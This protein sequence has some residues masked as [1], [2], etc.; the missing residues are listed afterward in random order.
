M[1]VAEFKRDLNNNY[2]ILE[3]E[4]GVL[5]SDYQI[6][7]ITV[8]S[9]GGILKC[10]TRILDG[11]VKLYFEITSKQPMTR[12]FEKKAIGME[13]LGRIIMGIK[14][15]IENAGEYLLDV[16]NLIFDPEYIYMN[17][18][19]GEMYFCYLP[20]SENEA[21]SSF[22][23]LA[24]YL[25]GRLDHSDK[26]GVV[27][28]YELYKCTME[29]NYSM[30][31]I[32]N[33]ISMK[34][35]NAADGM[36]KEG[37]GEKEIVCCHEDYSGRQQADSHAGKGKEQSQMPHKKLESDEKLESGEK[38]IRYILGG[39][40]FV[41]LAA[42]AVLKAE[43]IFGISSAKAA[44]AVLVI[45]G[46]ALS[47]AGY[48]MCRRKAEKEYEDV[49]IK[50]DYTDRMKNE[51]EHRTESGEESRRINK[52]FMD[53]E[54]KA[55]ELEAERIQREEKESDAE[56]YG[57]TVLLAYKPKYEQRK[58]VAIEAG[59]GM[60][61]VI[62]K[63]PF[64]L[65]KMPEAADGIIND[66]AVSRIHAEIIMENKKYFV[67]DLNSTNGTFLNGIRLEAN[68]KL[69]LNIDDEVRI[70]WMSFSFI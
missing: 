60:E 50:T 54:E 19:T 56:A 11:R 62:S 17:I 22:H 30:D 26:E 63:Y 37:G 21:S 24:E 31:S 43:E 40:A 29:E 39:L 51:I 2:L 46:A 61:I 36:E 64:V 14:K 67:K 27:I 58:L 28:G 20:Y 9:I 41:I 53:E 8:N 6:R 4:K 10:N 1:P 44:V 34:I 32:M 16:D 48:R 7:M 45:A 33:S 35:L 49:V 23:K 18:G 13:E 15:A 68:E 57:N 25:L 5:G 66:S 47:A 65:G 12:V 42:A 59:N 52:R 69:E 38:I 3:T 55:D 70:G